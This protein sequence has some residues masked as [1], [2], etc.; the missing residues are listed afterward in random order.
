MKA[1]SLTACALACLLLA[2][3]AE[4]AVPSITTIQPL[5]MPGAYAITGVECAAARGVPMTARDLERNTML[6]Q[7]ALESIRSAAV[8]SVGPA[9]RSL[10]LRILF[11]SYRP[12]RK[13]VWKVVPIIGAMRSAAILFFVDDNGRSVGRYRL[14]NET[15]IGNA[16]VSAPDIEIGL[17]QGV[18][19]FVQNSGMEIAVSKPS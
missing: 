16:L 18:L 13:S 1:A 4:S 10:K 9:K 17:Q 19:E 14:Y 5:D 11:T 15:L 2:G 3:C 12:A 8:Q 7:A 6:M